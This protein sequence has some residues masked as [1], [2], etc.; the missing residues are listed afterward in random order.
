M[1]K[2]AQMSVFLTHKI[3]YIFL[4]LL[5][6][7]SHCGRRIQKWWVVFCAKASL[8]STPLLYLDHMFII[9]WGL[10]KCV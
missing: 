6:L 4:C 10:C 7:L 8:N 2:W 9:S 3:V 1:I 5:S